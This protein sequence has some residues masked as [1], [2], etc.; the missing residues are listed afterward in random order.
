[1]TM[2]LIIHLHTRYKYEKVVTVLSVLIFSNFHPVVS[3]TN[4]NSIEFSPF[5]M[6]TFYSKLSNYR[7]NST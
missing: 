6:K 1:M 7:K 5:Y 2:S 3:V 4:R